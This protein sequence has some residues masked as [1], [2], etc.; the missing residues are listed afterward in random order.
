MPLKL[1]PLIRACTMVLLLLD[2]SGLWSLDSSRFNY[3]FL[4]AC[5]LLA[6]LGP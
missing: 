5:L 2:Y 1:L 4:A 3:F 6:F